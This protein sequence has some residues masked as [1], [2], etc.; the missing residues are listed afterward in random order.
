[1]NTKEHYIS[2]ALIKRFANEQNRIERFK[3]E[4][5]KWDTTAPKSVFKAIGYNQ[6][7]AFGTFDDS[8]DVEF[9]KLE[10]VS[11]AVDF[12]NGSPLSDGGKL[13]HRRIA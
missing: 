13:R 7:L 2:K 5:G 1:M 11:E 4:F 9:R 12:G 8:L 6:L 3:L 10:Q